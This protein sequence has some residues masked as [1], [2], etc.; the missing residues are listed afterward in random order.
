MVLAIAVFVNIGVWLIEQV[1]SIPFEFL[2]V[3]YIISELFLLGLHLV[4]TEN[5]LSKDQIAAETVP[6]APPSLPED[7][8]SIL[9]EAPSEAEPQKDEK[10]V[11]KGT[12]EA[13][14]EEM[15]CFLKGMEALTPTERAIFDAYLAGTST[16]EILSSMNIK[17]N[18]LKFHNK[19]IYGKLGVC[20]RRRLVFVYRAIEEEQKKIDPSPFK[21]KID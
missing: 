2:S 5:L 18:T 15:E 7:D 4:A 3:S 8:T 20:S 19:N 1:T 11:K 14:R 17:E 9:E 16:K 21:Q 6:S 12:E 10:P 13:T